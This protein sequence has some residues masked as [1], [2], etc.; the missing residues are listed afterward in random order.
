M[1]T[2]ESKQRIKNSVGRAFI[3]VISLLLQVTWLIVTAKHLL[4]NSE[5]FNYDALGMDC[6]AARLCAKYEF[7]L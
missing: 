6:G 2:E 1:Q 7:G 3:V 4:K 5:V